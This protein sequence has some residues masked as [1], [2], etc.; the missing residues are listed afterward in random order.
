MDVE[1]VRFYPET[2]RL[3]ARQLQEEAC[4]LIPATSL[5]LSLT[6]TQVRR[7]INLSG[8]RFCGP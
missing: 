6:C 1:V 8:G 7:M 3:D 2:H 5:L 4:V